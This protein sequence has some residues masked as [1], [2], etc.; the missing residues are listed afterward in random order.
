MTPRP[1]KRVKIAAAAVGIAAVV[2]GVALAVA[3]IAAPGTAASRTVAARPILPTVAF[4]VSHTRTALA[5]TTSQ[6]FIEY[7]RESATPGFQ[8]GFRNHDTNQRV[9][10]WTYR[11]QDRDA[12]YA[13]TGRLLWELSFVTKGGRTTTTAVTH[14]AKTWWRE[15]LAASSVLPL[16]AT[17]PK[18]LCGTS[19]GLGD[20]DKIDTNLGKTTRQALSCGRFVVAGIQRV[21]GVR[22]LKL[23]RPGSGIVTVVIWVDPATGKVGAVNLLLPGGATRSGMTPDDAPDEVCATWLDPAI[24]GPPVV[25]RASDGQTGQTVVATEFAPHPPGTWP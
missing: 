12:V 2:A 4:V 19:A 24:M 15:N 9:A 22:A 18:S 21:D 5:R 17:A 13:S 16:S 3:T 10:W 11:G 8:I 6:N 1:G 20:I 25:W 23:K 14:V 7:V